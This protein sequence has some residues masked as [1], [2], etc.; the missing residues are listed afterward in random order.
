MKKMKSFLLIF[1]LYFN[2]YVKAECADVTDFNEYYYGYWGINLTQ[3]TERTNPNVIWDTEDPTQ[4]ILARDRGMKIF[5]FLG[6][7]LFTGKGGPIKSNWRELFDDAYGDVTNPKN[8]YN[9]SGILPNAPNGFFTCQEC[10]SGSIISEIAH[11]I[12]TKYPE[13][14][15]AGGLDIANIKSN[16]NQ[17]I[18]LISIER[19]WPDDYYETYYWEDSFDAKVCG[20]PIRD[21]GLPARRISADYNLISQYFQGNTKVIWST[22]AYDSKYNYKSSCH[23]KKYTYSTEYGRKCDRIECYKVMANRTTETV[24]HMCRDRSEC[25]ETDMYGDVHSNRVRGIWLW[26]WDPR[27]DL[28]GYEIGIHEMLALDDYD[29]TFEIIDCMLFNPASYATF[30]LF[31]L[32]FSVLLALSY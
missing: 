3:T 11:H 12:K 17:I 22:A 27:P 30:N 26:H 7:L 19:Y 5:F 31:A 10:Y 6:N 28:I 20:N 1:L 9:I 13:A 21:G 32:T 25:G 29:L 16:I 2:S 14:L 15:V 23:P 4:L 18:D 8:P 24:S